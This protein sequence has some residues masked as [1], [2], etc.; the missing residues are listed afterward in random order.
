MP[1]TLYSMPTNTTIEA[2]GSNSA[3]VK[4]TGYGWLK[5]TDNCS[6]GWWDETDTIS[7]SEEKE[8]S[9]RKTSWWSDI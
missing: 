3:L 1:A 8:S 2:R 6:S 7:Y 4:T 5:I 9:K